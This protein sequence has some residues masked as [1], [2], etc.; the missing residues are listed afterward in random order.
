M[1]FVYLDKTNRGGGTLKLLSINV[2]SIH[3]KES[4]E[5]IS[6]ET[7][8]QHNKERMLHDAEIIKE[9]GEVT[10]KGE[11]IFAEKQIQEARHEMLYDKDPAY[12]AAF[13]EF[14]ANVSDVFQKSKVEDSLGQLMGAI[15]AAKSDERSRGI[16]DR[17]YENEVKWKVERTREELDKVLML[18]PDI[19]KGVF[20]IEIYARIEEVR[21]AFGDFTM[22]NLSEG[23]VKRHKR[24][25]E[26]M[27]RVKNLEAYLKNRTK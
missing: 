14:L 18:L 16:V 15:N 22:W 26:L 27:E 24:G 19:L 4:P 8:A 25:V 9:G 1:F 20:S 23:A 3:M 13:E 10:S 12:K 11:I 6:E 21:N 5:N 2:K 17:M 7:K